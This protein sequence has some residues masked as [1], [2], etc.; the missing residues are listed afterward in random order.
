MRKKIARWKGKI[1]KGI[2]PT[3]VLCGRPITN[4]NDLTTEH[5]IPIS[6]G[7]NSSETNIEPAHF[8][9]NQEKGNMTYLEWLVYLS[10]KQ[11][12]K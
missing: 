7:G 10:N 11:R 3:C 1:P 4:I 5:L 12:Q 9:C 6:R 8:R 2:Y